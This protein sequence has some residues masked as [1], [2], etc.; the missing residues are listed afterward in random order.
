ML[1]R[2]GVHPVNTLSWTYS[3]WST[4]IWSNIIF[5]RFYIVFFT[6]SLNNLL[7]CS[8]WLIVVICEHAFLVRWTSFIRPRDAREFLS[9]TDFIVGS[10]LESFSE[11]LSVDCC[12]LW[13]HVPFHLRFPINVRSWTS[14]LDY[15]TRK[16]FDCFFRLSIVFFASFLIDVCFILPPPSF[17]CIHN[18]ACLKFR[19][20][21]PFLH[22]FL[23]FSHESLNSIFTGGQRRNNVDWPQIPT[24]FEGWFPKKRRTKNLTAFLTHSQFFIWKVQNKSVCMICEVCLFAC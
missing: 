8:F 21:E 6:P 13:V 4:M 15:M 3:Y 11:H 18:M 19:I 5:W 9:V 7:A 10:V 24:D 17:L 23:I 20:L 22:A 14:L 12:D 2:W 1:L 16:I